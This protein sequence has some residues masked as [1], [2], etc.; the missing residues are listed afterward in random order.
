MSKPKLVIAGCARDCSI[1]LDQIFQNVSRLSLEYPELGL[2]VVENDSNDETGEKLSQYARH[3]NKQEII[4]IP[5]LTQQIP[6]RTQRLAFVRNLIVDVLREQRFLETDFV[7]MIDF[8]EV[9]TQ[10]WDVEVI[11][12]VLAFMKAHSSIAACFSN[13]DGHYYDLWALRHPTVCPGDIWLNAS[14]HR[15]KTNCSVKEAFEKEVQPCIFQ[16]P[17]TM[18]PFEVDSAFGGMGIYAMDAI[19]Q[20]TG[21]YIGEQFARVETPDGQII[22]RYQRCEHVPFHRGIA[23]KLGA[24]FAIYPSLITQDTHPRRFIPEAMDVLSLG[25]MKVTS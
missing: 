8:D 11:A 24:R 23:E 14:L 17:R 20:T 3:F 6:V 25:V 18:N 15:L 9:C 22:L 5:G 21:L 19:R 12:K 4:K 7:V 2:V 10:A 1:H 13:C 16:I